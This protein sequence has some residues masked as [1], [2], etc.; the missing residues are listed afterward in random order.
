MKSKDYVFYTVSVLS[1]A[2]LVLSPIL[3]DIVYAQNAPITSVLQTWL[4]YAENF[5]NL[6]VYATVY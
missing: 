3:I 4:Q 2:L 6:K 5:V 1:L